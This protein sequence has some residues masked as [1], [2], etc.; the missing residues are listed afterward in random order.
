[1]LI[2]PWWRCTAL[3]A[4]I[5]GCLW[6]I[7]TPV[8]AETA[9][10]GC[11][12]S[13]A[14][15]PQHARVGCTSC[16]Q[17]AAGHPGAA[18][19]GGSILAFAGEPAARRGAACSACHETV[20]AAPGSSAH[21]RAGVAC[22]DCHQMHVPVV[23]D[24]AAAA[25]QGV[26]TT[27]R[28]AAITV[29]AGC[30]EDVLAQFAYNERHRLDTGAVTC[31]SCHDPHGEPA[32]SLLGAAADQVCERC[33]VDAGGPFV[34][35]HGASRAEGCGACHEPHG[36]PN[37]HLLTHQREGELCYSC[38][39]VVP[40]FHVGFGPGGPPRFTEDTVCTNCHT[41]I[42]GSNFDRNLLR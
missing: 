40:Q 14:P 4:L 15:A 24:P 3:S 22:N 13:V 36:S 33:H 38:H 29:C 23:S 27:A 26:R 30:H 25:A 9:C 19:D 8:R 37:R 2:P 34:F 1:M 18:P 11:H 10:V 7:V 39:A 12:P 32:R 20:L 17:N 28:E 42:H 41:A 31:T 16:H 21:E 6:L 35:E 5:A